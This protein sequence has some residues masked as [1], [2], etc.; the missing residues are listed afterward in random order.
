MLSA[1][2]HRHNRGAAQTSL[3]QGAQSRNTKAT[4][5]TLGGGGRVIN[6]A[7]T[8]IATERIAC[9]TSRRFASQALSQASQI[10][11]PD[12]VT[13]FH[14]RHIPKLEPQQ[15][16]RNMSHNSIK[17]SSPLKDPSTSSFK[18][19]I[20]EKCRSAEVERSSFCARGRAVLGSGVLVSRGRE[21]GGGFSGLEFPF[22]RSSAEGRSILFFAGGR[23][24]V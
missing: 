13:S 11:K 14:G 2:L 17:S 6:Q 15:N 4:R 21:G 19:L 18:N 1:S 8:D 20:P 12:K 9:K 10:S 23:G 16:H 22:V 5:A 3:F 24:G 7:L